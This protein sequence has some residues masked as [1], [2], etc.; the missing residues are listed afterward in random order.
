LL[1]GGL[2][3][4]DAAT[5]V[6]RTQSV[7][8]QHRW[9]ERGAF[10]YSVP[11]ERASPV[12]PNGTVLGM[13]EPAYFSTVSPRV[14]LNFTWWLEEPAA[15][16]VDAAGFV[17]AVVRAEAPDGRA[18][19][20]LEEPLANGTLAGMGQALVMSGVLDVPALDARLHDTLRELG[21]GEAKT[22]WQVVAEVRFAARASWGAVQNESVFRM[23]M[24][25]SPPL[26]ML[27]GPDLA[28]SAYAHAEERVLVQESRAGFVA[29]L[30]APLPLA[31]VGLGGLGLALAARARPRPGD[32]DGAYQRDRAKHAD[33][34]VA[35]HGPIPPPAEGERVLDMDNVDDLVAMAVE[36]RTRVLLDE[37]CR[38]FWVFTPGAVY[39]FAGH[40]HDLP[41]AMAMRAGRASAEGAPPDAEATADPATKY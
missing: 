17:K 5:H 15:V 12:F 2:W 26:Y 7:E 40:G 14:L 1:I 21:M 23:D 6:E 31:A 10:A 38:V 32:G 34:V 30:R 8:Q 24:D 9:V 4:A 18:Y 41:T 27:P 11:V 36:A 22:T 19:W 35:V 25:R 33:W 3:L 39:R 37:Y 28:S 29:A 20:T 13:G 16:P